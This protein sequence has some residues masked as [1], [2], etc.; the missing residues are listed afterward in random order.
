[1]LDET[2]GIFELEDG[3]DIKRDSERIINTKDFRKAQLKEDQS[4]GDVS[5][6]SETKSETKSSKIRSKIR[7]K[8]KLEKRKMKQN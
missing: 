7:N 4:K 5:T 3:F 1:M 8:F 6:K 2:G